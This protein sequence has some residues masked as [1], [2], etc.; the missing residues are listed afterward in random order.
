VLYDNI[1]FVVLAVPVCFSM[2]TVMGQCEIEYVS[3]LGLSHM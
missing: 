3:Q 2:L 1:T